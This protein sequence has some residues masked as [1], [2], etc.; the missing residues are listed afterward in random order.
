MVPA[1]PLE[2]LLEPYRPEAPPAQAAGAAVV[3]LLRAGSLGGE[4]LLI[5]RTERVGDPA[6][7]QVSFPG[8]RV[9]PGDASLQATALRELEEEVG[10]GRDDL[11]GPP[12]FV[13]IVDA[14]RF[15]MK[16]G[17]FAARIVAPPRRE[18]TP[19]PAEVASV[20]WLPHQA[21]AAPTR[22]PRETMWGLREV[23][24]VVFAR[25]VLWGFTLHVLSE[26]VGGGLR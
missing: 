19:S 12:R 9:D 24:A 8:G 10:L 6:S 18:P 5:E 11:D 14:P 4:T 22:V 26:F 2:S 3:I 20:F 25:H 23:D 16:V 17:V 15:G 21:L 1:P 7:G 13:S